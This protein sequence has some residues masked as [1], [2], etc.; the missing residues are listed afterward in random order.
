M[1]IFNFLA[2]FLKFKIL[3]KVWQTL[4]L[5]IALSVDSLSHLNGTM[6]PFG[7]RQSNSTVFTRPCWCQKSWFVHDAGG[8]L[9]LCRNWL[10]WILPCFAFTNGTSK[11]NCCKEI[12]NA[13]RLLPN[14]ESTISK[15]IHTNQISKLQIT[16]TTIFSYSSMKSSWVEKQFN[17]AK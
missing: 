9:S 6:I 8:I 17:I 1:C 12:D 5:L 10:A 13:T 7:R 2:N 16:F 11:E 14:L 4:T 3:F 15:W